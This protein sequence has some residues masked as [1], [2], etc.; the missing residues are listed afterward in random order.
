MQKIT[1]W[2]LYLGGEA[3]LGKDEEKQSQFM[4]VNL[5]EFVPQDHLLRTIKRT[6]DFTFIYDKVKDLYSPVGRRSVDPVLLVKMLLI[7][8]WYGIASER[9]LEQEV[10]LNLA[11]RW[12]LGLDLAESVPDHSTISQNRRRRFKNSPLFQ[13]IFDTIVSRCVEEGL[14]TGEVIVTDSTHIKAS[15]SRQRAEKIWVEKTPTE[16]MQTLEQEAQRLEAELEKKRDAAGKKKC[17]KKRQTQERKVMHEVLVSKTDPDAGYMNRPGKPVGFHYLGHT[18][19]DTK[20]GII[21]DVHATAGN[22]NDHAPFIERV[23][24][25]KSRLGLPIKAIGAD[26]GYDRSEVHYGLEQEQ[27]TGYVTPLELSDT[28][29]VIKADFLYDKETDTFTCPEGRQLRWTHVRRLKEAHI[30]KIYAAKTTD[31][32]VCPNRKG[33]FGPK[34]KFRILHVALFHEY[35][36]RNRERATTEDYARIQRLRRIWCEGSFG[37]LKTQHNMVMTHKRGLV[38]IQEQC[39]LAASALNIKRMVKALA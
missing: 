30:V 31:C 29:A 1:V 37:I 26:K 2:T 4:F 14:V 16:Y 17:G 27:I 35:D 8:Y 36:K 6:I 38:N 25:L 3:M 20:H 32:K 28:E 21:T 9:K 7:G 24:V 34:Q 10:K 13:E 18:S 15:A 19:V 5:D 22:I 39:L 11:Y 23:K 33:C 12:F